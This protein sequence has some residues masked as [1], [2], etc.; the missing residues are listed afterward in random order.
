[1][2]V[3]FANLPCSSL[4]FV[5]GLNGDHIGTW[6]HDASGVVW[7]RDLIPQKMP[8]ARVLSF[9]YDADVHDDTSV[10]RIRDHAR[11]LLNFLK[12]ERS[13]ISRKIPIVFIA[14]SLGGLVVKQ[15]RPDTNATL[16]D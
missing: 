1:M 13:D 16:P 8:H 2:V 3:Q 14:H 11:T 6:K 12:D 5:H 15:V 4:V 9:S 7:P 10:S